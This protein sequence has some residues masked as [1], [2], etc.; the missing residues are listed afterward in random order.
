MHNVLISYIHLT[1]T[2]YFNIIYIPKLEKHSVF[3]PVLSRTTQTS[4]AI[5]PI[6]REKISQSRMP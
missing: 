5:R 2:R 4:G 3:L 6:P 1:N